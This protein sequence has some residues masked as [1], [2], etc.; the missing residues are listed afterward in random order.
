MKNCLG[1]GGLVVLSSFGLLLFG[2][3]GSTAPV[4]REAQVKCESTDRWSPPG[5]NEALPERLEAED[6]FAWVPF[7]AVQRVEKDNLAS[8]KRVHVVRFKQP[9]GAYSYSF[10]PHIKADVEV[11]L[12]YRTGDD[13]GIWNAWVN[14]DES[15]KET[16]DGYGKSATF[17][18]VKVGT[19]RGTRYH[20]R[21]WQTVHIALSGKN[22]KS[23]SFG[24]T[25]DFVELREIATPSPCENQPDGTSCD[26]GDACTHPDTCQAGVC[27]GGT[28]V[29]CTAMDACHDVGVCD[30]TTG[31]C[32]NPVLPDGTACEDGDLCTQQDS[33]QAGSCVGGTPVTCPSAPNCL[34]QSACVPATG[35]CSEAQ[36]C[37]Q[38][39]NGQQ[40]PGEECDDG[41]TFSDDG[42][43]S[44]CK[45]E[46]CGDGVVQGTTIQSLTFHYL[47]RSCNAGS[48]AL[49]TFFLNG[50]VVAQE[51]LPETCD[52]EPGIRTLT[53]TDPA[54]RAASV[55]GTNWFEMSIDGELAWTLASIR[56]RDMSLNTSLWDWGGGNDAVN[57]NP[58]LC[59]AGALSGFS[60]GA[61]I[62]LSG[63]ETCDDGNNVDGDGC[64]STCLATP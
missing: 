44:T 23:S 17:A 20:R 37:A 13:Q 34:V 38:C 55:N 29:V 14:D 7:K 15:A 43:S 57:M 48:A 2:C 30:S 16:V 12:R 25:M 35:V 19:I 11:W 50:V 49:I 8:K 33:C 6:L 1:I 32:S 26:D 22:P 51:P 27:V 61:A 10:N 59:A 31:A 54:L 28:P 53:I 45:N 9:N 62:D 3:E 4:A 36:G 64:S 24:V 47:G 52:C 5:R 18:E 63:G 21:P 42:C 40:D 58:D 56:T 41:N 39:G 46:Y 60:L